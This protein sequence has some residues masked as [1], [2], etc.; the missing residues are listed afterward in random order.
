[1]QLVDTHCHLDFDR[2][3]ADREQVIAQAVKDGI[4]SIIN[5][6]IMRANCKPSAA[7][8]STRRWLLSVK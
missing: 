5:P 1:M 8:R 2:F 4:V 7:W 6:G 3:D